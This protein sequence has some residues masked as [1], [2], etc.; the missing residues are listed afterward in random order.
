MLVIF[1][2]CSTDKKAIFDEWSCIDDLWQVYTSERQV[3]SGPNISI[4]DAQNRFLSLDFNSALTILDSSATLN[5]AERFI[6][7]LI[8][9]R[10]KLSENPESK[11]LPSLLNQLEYNLMDLDSELPLEEELLLLKAKYYT[12]IN[13]TKLALTYI[14]KGLKVLESKANSNFRN[15]IKAK[16][17]GSKANILFDEGEHF[18]ETI[19]YCYNTSL[20]LIN[21]YKYPNTYGKQKLNYY[22]YVSRLDEGNKDNMLEE[23]LSSD[24]PKTPSFEQ[25]LQ[26]NLGIQDTINGVHYFLKSLEYTIDKPC[27]KMNLYILSNI[28]DYY[29]KINPDSSKY[30]LEKTKQFNDCPNQLEEWKDFYNYNSLYSSEKITAFR[31]VNKAIVNHTIRRQLAEKLFQQE[32][33]H[34][35]DFY[36]QNTSE[37]CEILLSKNTLVPKHHIDPLRSLFNDT[38]FKHERI[39]NYKGKKSTDSKLNNLLKEVNDFRDT[40]NYDSPV[41]DQLY[42]LLANRPEQ[43]IEYLPKTERMSTDNIIHYLKFKED[44]YC[45]YYNDDILKLHKFGDTTVTNYLAYQ[46]SCNRRLVSYNKDSIDFYIAQILPK[47]LTP[48][49]NL[50]IIT[51]GLLENISFDL[52]FSAYDHKYT[53]SHSPYDRSYHEQVKVVAD[54]SA[55]FSFSDSNTIVDSSPKEI[56]ELPYGYQECETIAELFDSKIYKGEKFTHRNFTKNLNKDLVHISTHSLHNKENRFENYLLI[57]KQEGLDSIFI[58]DL[59]GMECKAK[60]I[61]IASCENNLGLHLDG[62]GTFSISKTFLNAGA[63]TVLKTLWKVDDRAT[64]D[65]MIE[66]YRQWLTGISVLEAQ[67]K[68]K[69]YMKDSTEYSH[70]YYWAGFALEGNPNLYLVK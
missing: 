2:Q 1:A 18:K 49:D 28:V 6:S 58:S 54:N 43:K 25:Y 40:S 63:E 23:L 4:T 33:I 48:S 47:Q 60:F 27:H 45:Y 42:E 12:N 5:K 53:I 17:L 56:S 46:D 22:Y 44:Y 20:S 65:F 39:T 11:E 19:L 69:K 62:N 70:P 29:I 55:V 38:K 15:L 41:Y 32:V 64:K 3:T 35:G 10:I 67:C 68:A 50:T 34:L 8:Q 26:F 24:Y 59:T 16:L 21:K 14:H 66:F 52:L 31:D 57:R 36:S 51:D 37:I 61:S 7:K 9:T 30:Y 13:E